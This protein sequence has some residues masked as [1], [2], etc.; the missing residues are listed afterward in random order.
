MNIRQIPFRLAVLTT[1]SFIRDL[2]DKRTIIFNRA[3]WAVGSDIL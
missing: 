2:P 3:G 1:L